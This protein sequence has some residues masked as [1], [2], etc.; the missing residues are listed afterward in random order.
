MIALDLIEVKDFM[1]KF[2][3]TETFDHFLIRE[4]VISGVC[5]WNM[6]GTLDP[7][8]YSEEERAANGLAGLSYL[9]FGQARIHSFNLIKGKRTPSYFKFIL[10]LSPENLARTLEQSRSSFSPEDITGCFLNLTFSHGT[11]RLTTGISYRIFSVDKS[12]DAEWDELV[13]RF[14]KN[15]AI[16]FQEL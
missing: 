1:N 8:F 7:E 9:P 5:T 4:A 13:K 3:C 14:L 16:A 2:L 10:L 6:D 12:F 15:H 11:L